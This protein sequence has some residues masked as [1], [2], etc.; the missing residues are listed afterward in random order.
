MSSKW[1]VDEAVKSLAN[2]KLSAIEKY[3]KA[4]FLSYFGPITN[5]IA[6]HIRNL[7]EEI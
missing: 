6:S 7:I 3:F 2:I 1:P 4:D 5:G